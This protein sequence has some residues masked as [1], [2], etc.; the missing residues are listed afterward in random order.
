MTGVT[1]YDLLKRSGWNV[2]DKC[3]SMKIAL[4]GPHDLVVF[5]CEIVAEAPLDESGNLQTLTKRYKLV[6]V[7]E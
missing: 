3:I 2:P 6:E 1:F 7:A 4:G 5:E